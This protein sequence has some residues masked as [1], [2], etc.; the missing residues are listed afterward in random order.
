MKMKFCAQTANWFIVRQVN[1]LATEVAAT[2]AEIT[3]A[4]WNNSRR[5]VFVGVAAVSA[6]WKARLQHDF[7][8]RKLL[9]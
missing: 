3:C 4:D 1:P 7:A 6:G 5:P 8:L 2:L 9:S